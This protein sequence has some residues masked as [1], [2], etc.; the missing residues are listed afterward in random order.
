MMTLGGFRY[1]DFRRH[2]IK[3]TPRQ[4]HAPPLDPFHETSCVWV[5]PL[6]GEHGTYKTVKARF[7]PWLLG[8]RVK[9]V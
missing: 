3:S 5:A 9:V 6:S 1:D 7:W 8:K 2:L 4:A